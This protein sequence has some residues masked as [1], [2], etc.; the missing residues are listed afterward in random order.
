VNVG[1]N[2]TLTFDEPMDPATISGSTFEL[3]TTSG[4][5]LV[6]ATVTYS[7]ATRTATLD[8]T[9]LLAF[10]TSFT[11]TM[12]GGLSGARD[13]AGNQLAA[14]YVWS[15][16]TE[17]ST[18]CPCTLF[19]DAAVPA[20]IAVDPNPLN[21]GM[22]FRSDASGYI[23]GLRYYRPAGTPGSAVVTG[24]LYALS[25]AELGAVTFASGAIEGWQNANFG[26][27][28]A[29]TAGT[30]YV[31]SYHT[32]A[33]RFGY[34]RP[35][36]FSVERV[37]LP[38]RAPASTPSAPNGSYQYSPVPAF[39]TDNPG[40]APNYFVDVIFDTVVDDHTAPLITSRFPAPGAAGGSD[41]D[42]CHGHVQRRHERRDDQRHDVRVARSVEC[43]RCGERHIRSGVADSDARSDVAAPAV[44]DVHGDGHWWRER[45]ERRG[46]QRA[47]RE[48]ELELHHGG[49]R[50]D[51]HRWRQRHCARGFGRVQRDVGN[52]H[53][54]RP[55]HVHGLE[56]QRRA[57][58]GRARDLAVRHALVHSGP[59]CI[60]L[61]ERLGVR[62]EFRRH[63]EHDGG[64]HD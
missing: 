18:G 39:P 48:C 40:D 45:S 33:G 47:R 58:L 26:T 35:N 43:R 57:V 5:T 38:L 12:K 41:V 1:S 32:N 31:A 21:L 10:G 30:T 36:Y 52:G 6:P 61:R 15:F 24:H 17:T 3:R 64:I 56:Q 59:E 20:A 29:I 9:A 8:P 14:D 62:D 50:T 11:A 44:G 7:A 53:H 55:R 42:E 22:R 60:R 63:A 46:G 16:T 2:I 49:C 27:P 54:G 51:V 19:D 23:K 25:G 28:V 34:T 37:N 4:G 13:V